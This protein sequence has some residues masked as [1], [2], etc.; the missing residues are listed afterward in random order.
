MRCVLMLSV[1][2]RFRN[3]IPEGRVELVLRL[4][5][6]GEQSRLAF[7][8]ERGISTEPETQA[9]SEDGNVSISMHTSCK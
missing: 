7:F 3:I 8:V 4:Y 5:D 6:L 9:F 1:N 2:T